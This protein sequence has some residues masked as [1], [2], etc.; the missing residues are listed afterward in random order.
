LGR[1]EGGD[2]RLLQRV[3]EA[4]GQGHFGPTTTRS[5]PKLPRRRDDGFRILGIEAPG[6]SPAFGA[7]VA[8]RAI[9]LVLR[10]AFSAVAKDQASA[11]SR[12]PDPAISTFTLSPS[13]LDLVE[14]PQDGARIDAM[15]CCMDMRFD[16]VQRS[17]VEP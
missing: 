5:I 10:R 6:S 12:A 11:C 2:A 9:D 16:L 7:R 13:G 17:S 14:K 1:P 15:L 3:H 4:R 8:R